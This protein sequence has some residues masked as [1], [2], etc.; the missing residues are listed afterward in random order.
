M[1]WPIMDSFHTPDNMGDPTLESKLFSA[2]TGIETDEQGL[3]RYGE[4]IFNLQRAVLLK[5]GWKAKED[6]Y[7]PEY[8]FTEPVE[9]S[10][11][12]PRMI[13]PGPTEEPVSFKGNI[14]DRAKYEE[15]R[16]E[17]YELRGWDVD[18]GLQTA[19]TMARLDLADVATELKKMG[20]LG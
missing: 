16:R 11:I 4:R 9:M 12:N 6:D 14:L 7:P 10:A 3:L 13:I 19:E 17:F 8:N 5:E 1:N 2:V 20:M 15:M 18:T